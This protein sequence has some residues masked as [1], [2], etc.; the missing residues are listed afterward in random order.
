MINAMMGHKSDISGSY[1][2]KSKPMFI[3]AYFKVEPLITIYGSDRGG[4]SELTERLSDL[5]DK[6]SIREQHID[7]LEF[8]IDKLKSTIANLASLVSEMLEDGKA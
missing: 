2:S 8:D 7:T 1:L 5:E 6:I 4:W 3:S